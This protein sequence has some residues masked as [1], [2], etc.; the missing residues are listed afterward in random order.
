M[1]TVTKL[2]VGSLSIM[3]KNEPGE[4]LSVYCRIHGCKCPPAP[5]ARAPTTDAVLAWFLAGLE[6][7]KGAPGRAAHAAMYRDLLNSL[8][9]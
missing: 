1:D 3:R 8:K 9:K 5:V 7:P 2:P 6:L 4:A